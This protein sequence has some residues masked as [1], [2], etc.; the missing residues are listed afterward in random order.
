MVVYCS[1]IP[2]GYTH[3]QEYQQVAGYQRLWEAVL[4]EQEGNSV[5]FT[6]ERELQGQV[7]HR[8]KRRDEKGERSTKMES[9]YMTVCERARDTPW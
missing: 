4:K 2:N 8:T 6:A 7:V 9:M 3:N 1:A 5:I